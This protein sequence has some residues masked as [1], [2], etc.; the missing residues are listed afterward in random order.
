LTRFHLLASI[1]SVKLP[2][3]DRLIVEREKIVDYLLNPAHPFGASKAH[4]F[5]RFGFEVRQWEVFAESLR[6]HGRANDVTRFRETPFGPRYEV[7]G[8]LLAA[9]GRRPRIRTVWQLDKGEVAPR[10]ITAYPVEI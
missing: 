9:D 6:Q 10:L 1:R 3:P 2:S 5:R 4:F 8:E 7:E